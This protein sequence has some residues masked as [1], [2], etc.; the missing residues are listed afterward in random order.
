MRG[1]GVKKDAGSKKMEEFSL[2][3]ETGAVLHKGVKK[4]GNI[5]F[6]RDLRGFSALFAVKLTAENAE[7]FRRGPQRL[8]CGNSKLESF[9]HDPNSPDS[10]RDR[11]TNVLSPPKHRNTKSHRIFLESFSRASGIELLNPICR[12]VSFR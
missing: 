11:D 4:T 5:S 12:M 3:I 2:L 10:Y 7:V 8:F 9:R 6:L 1:E